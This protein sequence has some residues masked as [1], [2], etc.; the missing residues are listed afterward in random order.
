M[1]K[2]MLKGKK[3]ERDLEGPESDCFSDEMIEGTAVLINQLPDD[4]SRNSLLEWFLEQFPCRS[5]IS[6]ICTKIEG[7]HPDIARRLRRDYGVTDQV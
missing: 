5:T 2:A 1:E 6:V 3:D 7:L 4:N